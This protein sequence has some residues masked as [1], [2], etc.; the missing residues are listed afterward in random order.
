MALTLEQIGSV[1]YE[2]VKKLVDKAVEDWDKWIE[3]AIFKS[4]GFYTD[5]QGGRRGGKT[6][7]MN[8]TTETFWRNVN[9]RFNPHIASFDY[10]NRINTPEDEITDVLF[11]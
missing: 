8:R 10:E 1:Q 3:D 4:S 11:D 5:M 9:Y 6:W 7:D 2:F